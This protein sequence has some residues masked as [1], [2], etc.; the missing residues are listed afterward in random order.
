MLGVW[1]ELLCHAALTRPTQSH[2][3]G[4]SRDARAALGQRCQVCFLQNPLEGCCMLHTHQEVS[5]VLGMSFGTGGC[6]VAS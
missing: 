3:K 6:L 4:L 5:Q 1:H 2:C